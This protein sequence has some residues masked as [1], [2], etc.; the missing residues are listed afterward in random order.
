LFGSSV[1]GSGQGETNWGFH[2]KALAHRAGLQRAYIGQL[3]TGMRSPG[4][5]TLAKLAR[6]LELDAAGR[7]G[8]VPSKKQLRRV[9]RQLRLISEL[10]EQLPDNS[11]PDAALRVR[12]DLAADV[13]EGA[14]KAS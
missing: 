7:M 6:A 14:A 9:A 11:P 5:E 8:T 1:I 4:L 2:K 13:L 12:L 10:T 3:E